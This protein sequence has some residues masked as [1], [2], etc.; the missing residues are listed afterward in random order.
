M[1]VI[2]PELKHTATTL[3]T[4]YSVEVAGRIRTREKGMADCSGVH[5]LNCSLTK[6]QQAF[7]YVDPT[8]W[9]TVGPV[10]LRKWVQVP[11]RWRST[12]GSARQQQ[13]LARS[14]RLGAKGVP[15]IPRSCPWWL[16]LAI[17]QRSTGEELLRAGNTLSPALRCAQSCMVSILRNSVAARSLGQP[18]DRT[19]TIPLWS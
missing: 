13:A 19:S 7:I 3:A 4:T 17:S 16:N 15:L 18:R 12:P 8:V 10:I 6:R 5:T 1:H 14:H 2:Q 9:Y 11:K